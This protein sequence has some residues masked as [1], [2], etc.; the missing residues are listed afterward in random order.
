MTT[1]DSRRTKGLFRVAHS[2]A[3]PVYDSLHLL[4]ETPHPLT[5]LALFISLG[6]KREKPLAGWETIM[7]ISE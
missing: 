1:R 5:N 6:E 7:P 3:L 4:V 2:R